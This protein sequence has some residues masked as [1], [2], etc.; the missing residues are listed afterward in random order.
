MN[1][2]TK[3]KPKSYLEMMEQRLDTIQKIQ[4]KD[5][6]EKERVEDT[7]RKFEVNIQSRH[8]AIIELQNSIKVYKQFQEIKDVPK[9]IPDKPKPDNPK[10]K[11][12]KA[13]DK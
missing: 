11:E 9:P 12:L 2:E 1:E 5:L 3:P 4:I 7:M 10:A 13:S 8:G 6:E